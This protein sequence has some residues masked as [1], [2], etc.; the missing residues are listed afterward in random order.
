MFALLQIYNLQEDDFASLA[1]F[2][3]YLEHVEEIVFN[4]ANDIDVEGIEAEV[5]KFKEE[6][7][8]KIE[9]NR[10]RLNPDDLWI[11]EMLNE[12]VNRTK[13][14]KAE[15]HEEKVCNL[16]L[17]LHINYTPFLGN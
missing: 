6:Y 10:R 4:L 14:L 15:L 1:E 8:E 7:E 13:R 17:M 5:K 12:E 2:N 3:D 11:N 16:I 9:K